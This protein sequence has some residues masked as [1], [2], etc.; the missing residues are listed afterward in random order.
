MRVGFAVVAS[1]LV[2][3]ACGAMTATGASSSTVVS[4]TVPSATSIDATGCASGVPGVTDFGAVLPGQSAVTTN[5]CVVSFGS[6]NAT[7][8]LMLTN[9]SGGGPAMSAS[10]T[11]GVV[12]RWPLNGDLIDRSP[13]GNTIQ[14]DVVNTPPF[15]AGAPD[16][17]QGMQFDGTNRAWVPAAAALELTN[18]TVDFWFRTPPLPAANWGE[19][20]SKS[21]GPGRN[22]QINFA[23]GNSLEY[24]VDTTGSGWVNM[25][26]GAAP[27]TDDQWHHLAAVG[28]SA[29]GTITLYVDGAYVDSRTFAGSIVTSSTPVNIGGNGNSAWT[30]AGRLDEVRIQ[31]VARTRSEVRGY[32]LGAVKNYAGGAS[33][34]TTGSNTFGA[35]LRAAG[36]TGV[37]AAWTTS[38]TCPATNG[39]Y[40]NAIAPTTGAAGSKIL[41]TSTVGA[42]DLV[43]NLRFGF[44]AAASQP[45][46]TYRASLVFTAVAP[47]A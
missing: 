15:T 12:G 16:M 9:A 14:R 36:G 39:T 33:D 25:F 44:R 45:P 19:L 30:F 26:V 31:D 28:N 37:V 7:S 46:G 23:A 27:W 47:N 17:D 1:L 22:Y 4:V 29:A 10:P 41:G 5:D 20:V 24:S 42:T 38:I 11:S 40:W 35:C 13:N 43:A 34:W 2:V 3:A 18:Y 32:Y 8:M 21:G 6:S